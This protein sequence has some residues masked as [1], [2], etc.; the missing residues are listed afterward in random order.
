MLKSTQFA[1]SSMANIQNPRVL[2]PVQLVLHGN[3]YLKD[4]SSNSL[5]NDFAKRSLESFNI[6]L[7]EPNTN[8]NR[9]MNA[10]DWIH[11]LHSKGALSLSLSRSSNKKQNTHNNSLLYSTC[12]PLQ[13][14]NTES[15]FVIVS[16]E[17]SKAWQ[18]GR[19]ENNESFPLLS[20]S[21]IN[22]PQQMEEHLVWRKIMLGEIRERIREAVERMRDFTILN[23]HK[24]ELPEQQKINFLNQLTE[25]EKFLHMDVM[26]TTPKDIEFLFNYLSLPYSPKNSQSRV[27]LQILNAAFSAYI[28]DKTTKITDPKLNED[29]KKLVI[30]LYDSVLDSVI[31]STNNYN[32]EY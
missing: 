25:A 23:F 9:V 13:T 14:Q 15:E 27:A 16:S 10:K 24:M 28:F 30:E 3:Q 32:S 6:S 19:D 31:C 22:S 17:I 29:F 4:L 1:L 12:T 26:V 2:Q 7:N 20:P 5:K 21:A 11:S 18:F 8:S